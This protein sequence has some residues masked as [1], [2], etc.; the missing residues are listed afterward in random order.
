MDHLHY[1]LL[2]CLF[3]VVEIRAIEDGMGTGRKLW[4]RDRM[5]KTSEE[6]EAEASGSSIAPEDTGYRTDQ[7]FDCSEELEVTTQFFVSTLTLV[8]KNAFSSTLTLVL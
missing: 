8:L 7:T 1:L 3:L 5:L 2:I 4:V 6:E